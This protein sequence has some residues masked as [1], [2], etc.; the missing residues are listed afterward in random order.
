[1]TALLRER[2]ELHTEHQR[3][4]EALH[5]HRDALQAKANRLTKELADFEAAV[6]LQSKEDDAGYRRA[7]D[8]MVCVA[9]HGLMCR[10]DCV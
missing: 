3:E 10:V 2:L 5:K 4:I 6:K 9:R 8:L 7:A 1:M